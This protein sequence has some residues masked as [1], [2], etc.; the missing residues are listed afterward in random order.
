MRRRR[1]LRPPAPPEYLPPNYNAQ[2]LLEFVGFV[3][4]C[5][6]GS[7]SDSMNYIVPAV[8]DRIRRNRIDDRLVLA[9]TNRALRMLKAE[10]PAG[11]EI[12]RYIVH[13][14]HPQS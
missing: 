5:Q 8:L 14:N 6:Q 2:L 13:P 11:H 10:Y 7:G 1:L 12:W 9:D 4:R 3:V